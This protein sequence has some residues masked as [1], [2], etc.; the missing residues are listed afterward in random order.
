M[1]I[2]PQPALTAAAVT[3]DPNNF[4]TNID[5]PYFTLRLGTTFIYKDKEANARN[6]F[7][8]TWET[9]VILGVTCVVVRDTAYEN[10]QVVEDTYDW[11]AQDK[12]GNVWY[13]GEFTQE[14]KPGKYPDKPLNS[15]GSWEAGVDGAQPGILIKANPVVGE[16]YMQENHPGVA[17]DTVEVI[18]LNEKVDV[19]YGSSNETLKTFDYTPLDPSALE[20]KYYIPGVGF[21]LDDESRRRARGARQD[22]RRGAGGKCK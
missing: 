6:T 3:I 13:F 5:N 10:G 16:V 4:T 2:V 17:E 11:F 18:A 19:V 9:K 14:F 22:H 15:A 12:Q 21:V 20:N 8:V 7:V 1:S